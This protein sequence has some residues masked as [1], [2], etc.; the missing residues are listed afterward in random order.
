MMI[1]Q[2][3]TT[4]SSV[5]AAAPYIN[6]NTEFDTAE[7]ALAGAQD[8]VGNTVTVWVENVDQEHKRISLTIVKLS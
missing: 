6:M 1:M 2:V 3:M 8:S 4:G 7:K 5:D